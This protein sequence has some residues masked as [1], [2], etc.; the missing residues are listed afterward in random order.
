MEEA[1]LAVLESYLRRVG[2]RPGNGL[3]KAMNS[4]LRTYPAVPDIIRRVFMVLWQTERLLQVDDA[5]RMKPLAIYHGLLATQDD[6]V[7]ESLAVHKPTWIE[8]ASLLAETDDLESAVARPLDHG[9]FAGEGRPQRTARQPYSLPA[10][11]AAM[12]IGRRIGLFV[13]HGQVAI[14]RDVMKAAQRLQR[15]HAA[16]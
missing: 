15:K 3:S 2:V 8:V 6:W 14:S 9:A 16:C 5:I 11:H 1:T 4:H 13:G 10:F 12:S 7:H